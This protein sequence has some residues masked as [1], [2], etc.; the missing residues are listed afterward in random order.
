MLERVHRRGFMP[1][2][3]AIHR[4]TGELAQWYGLDAGQISVV[5]RADIAVID[6]A[7]FDGSSSQYAEAPAAGLA[8]LTRMVN[9]NDRAV[10][11]T[12][13]NGHVVYQDGTFADG[14]GIT[15]HAGTYLR[16]AT[17]VSSTAR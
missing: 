12:I 3:S 9:R 14:F 16:A 7:V 8:N 6:P 2:A 17:R 13:V 15:P 5:S 11:A 10:A 1:L 4:L